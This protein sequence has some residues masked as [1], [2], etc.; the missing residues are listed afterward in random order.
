MPGD[1]VYFR[2]D[3]STI[4][5]HGT[6]DSIGAD[7]VNRIDWAPLTCIYGA[8]EGDSLCPDVMLPNATMV[9]MPG[10]HFLD[11]NQDE[12][13]THIFDAIRTVAPTVTP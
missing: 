2:S 1:K 4:A 3:P 11:H 8:A 9:K 13:F 7:T 5:Y 12:L 6:P 10:G